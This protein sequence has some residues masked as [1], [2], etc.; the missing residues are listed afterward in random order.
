MTHYRSLALA[1]ASAVIM[2]VARL[3]TNR[4]C[5]LRGREMLAAGTTSGFIPPWV[6]VVYLLGTVGL[7]VSFIW[8]LFAVGWLGALFVAAL[9]FATG[10]VRSRASDINA[11]IRFHQRTMA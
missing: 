4:H 5:N 1:V 10:F 8:S 9:Y 7:V 3:V 11:A 2:V 6:S